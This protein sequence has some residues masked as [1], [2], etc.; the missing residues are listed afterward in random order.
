MS[1]NSITELSFGQLQEELYQASDL[2][3][4]LCRRVSLAVPKITV[5][6]T[7][8]SIDSTV[9][10]GSRALPSV[11]NFYRNAVEVCST[12]VTAPL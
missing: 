5:Q 4:R 8:L 11:W 7:N 10:L 6:Y 2:T 1:V 12:G 3:R 9:H